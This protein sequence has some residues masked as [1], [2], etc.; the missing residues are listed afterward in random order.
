MTRFMTLLLGLFASTAALA[1]E[2]GVEH[3]DFSLLGIQMR[4]ANA[5]RNEAKI[6]KIENGSCGSL[7]LRGP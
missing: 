6:A 2:P 3:L 4:F 1:S 5:S 7:R